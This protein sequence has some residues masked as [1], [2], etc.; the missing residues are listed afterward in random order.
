MLN[1]TLDQT[2]TVLSILSLT[3]V[4]VRV[5]FVVFA[6]LISGHPSLSIRSSRGRCRDELYAPRWYWSSAAWQLAYADRMR[7]SQRQQL[8]LQ[9]FCRLGL[10]FTSFHVCTYLSNN[11]RCP[12]RQFG[13]CQFKTPH[14]PMSH[15]HH[16]SHTTFAWLNLGDVV[17]RITLPLPI[18]TSAGFLEIGLS[19]KI[20][21]QIRPPRLM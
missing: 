10:Q 2:V 7:F 15:Q 9:I 13:R 14:V 16:P 20:R 12:D 17:L 18:R 6:S 4:P 11:K 8:L 5:R 21:I 19:G 1:F 3:T